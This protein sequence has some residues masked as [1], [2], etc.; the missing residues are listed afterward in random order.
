MSQKYSRQHF[1]DLTSHVHEGFDDSHWHL[2]AGISYQYC[3][4]EMS[5]PTL[6]RLC[7]RPLLANSARSFAP[8]RSSRFYSS[9]SE[10]ASL[11]EGEKHIFDKLTK[12]LSP[13]RLRVV[14]VSGNNLKYWVL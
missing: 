3:T 4:S 9:E 10:S 14:D 2:P 8:L 7:S 11:S 1:L 13:L 5:L 6:T 12:E